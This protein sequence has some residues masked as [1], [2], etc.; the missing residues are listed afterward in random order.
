MRVLAG[1]TLALVLV[2]ALAGALDA[3]GVVMIGGTRLG[4]VRVQGAAVPDVAAVPGPETGPPCVTDPRYVDES[5][6]GLRADAL[7]A[8]ERASAEAA[9]HG[10]TLCLQDGKRSRRQQQAQFDDYVRRYGSAESA[11]QYVLPPH[12]SMH[13]L[14]VAVDVQPPAAAAWLERTA[15]ALGWCRQYENEPWH[16]E[17]GAGHRTAGCPPWRPH[18]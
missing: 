6:R 18:P 1:I 14:G 10:V 4:H 2:V 15:G 7:D 16:F 13:V 3:T 11:R 17:F 8:W 5:P 12:E 9:A